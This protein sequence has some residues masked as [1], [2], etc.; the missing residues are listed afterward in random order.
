MYY[1]GVWK[2]TRKL[3]WNLKSDFALK[4]LAEIIS[5][6]FG[7]QMDSYAHVVNINKLGKQIANCTIV[8]I[9]VLRL[10]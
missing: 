4:R 8:R 5:F 10:R 7:G 3:L 9:V 6:N 2:I 1:I